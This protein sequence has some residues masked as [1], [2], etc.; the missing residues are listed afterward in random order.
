MKEI[1]IGIA[2]GEGL[3]PPVCIKSTQYNRRT[4]IRPRH[5]KRNGVESNA[6]RDTKCRDLGRNIII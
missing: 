3:A 5:P 2:V 4:H 1:F 6:E